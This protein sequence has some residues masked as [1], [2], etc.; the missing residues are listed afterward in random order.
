MAKINTRG[1]IKFIVNGREE[2]RYY[3][4]AGKGKNWLRLSFDEL[5]EM[6]GVRYADTITVS[7]RGRGQT[8][9]LGGSVTIWTGAVVN[10]ANTSQA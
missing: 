9:P 5:A 4:K 6:A 8:V 1:E 2:V 10:V 7:Q 3:N